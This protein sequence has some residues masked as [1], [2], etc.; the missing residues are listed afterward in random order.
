MKETFE[1]KRK[2]KIDEDC[3]VF[4]Y[5]TAI[6]EP[7]SSVSAWTTSENVPTP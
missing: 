1:N 7:S 6:L 5:M 4:K 3:C 2:F